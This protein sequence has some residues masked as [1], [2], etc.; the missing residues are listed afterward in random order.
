LAALRIKGR[1]YIRMAFFANI[2]FTIL[3]GVIPSMTV[4]Q[5][6]FFLAAVVG[7]VLTGAGLGIVVSLGYSTG[8]TD[9]LGAI[10]HHFFPYYGVGKLLFV[11]D[12]IIILLGA[13]Q[14]G[15]AIA[16]YAVIAVYITSK[17]MDAII[18]GGKFA[19]MVYIIS[20]AYEEIGGELLHQIG[21]GV[22]VLDGTGMYT[23]KSR[24]ILLCAVGKKQIVSVSRIAH[25]YDENAF[26]IIS[27]IREV[28]GE[29]FVEKRQL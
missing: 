10:L 18:E 12:S 28:Q 6:D 2:C 14:F 5:E 20:D 24:R 15:I 4:S 7:G 13:W 11:L 19:K 17:L 26:V 9:L 29:G 22:T 1:E 27:D 8:G 16:V 21:R 23:G 25:K 3:L